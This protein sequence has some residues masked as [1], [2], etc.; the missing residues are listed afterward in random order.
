MLESASQD[1]AEQLY[2]FPT[3][4]DISDG[5]QEGKQQLDITLKP[6][7]RSLGLTASGVARQVRSAFY[8]SEVMRQQRGRNEV[9]VM[10]RL[11]EE[12]RSSEENI[13]DLLLMTGSGVQVPMREVVDIHRDRAFTT[14][15]RR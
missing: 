1:L 15:T 7:A 10:V 14:I 9:K 2:N 11:P 5:F 12:D 3:V 6:A 8:G 13:N 4:S